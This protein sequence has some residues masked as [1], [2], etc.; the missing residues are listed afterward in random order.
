MLAES[1]DGRYV[2]V[3]VDEL[4]DVTLD[5][6][7]HKRLYKWQNEYFTRT[8]PFS[9]PQAGGTSPSRPTVGQ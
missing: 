1:D 7:L 4:V 3:W 6:K 8:R 5:K 9:S 2:F